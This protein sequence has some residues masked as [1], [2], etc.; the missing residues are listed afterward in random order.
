[1]QL[2]IKVGEVEQSVSP[3]QARDNFAA[4]I[5][6]YKVENPAKYEIKKDKLE[7]ELAKLEAACPK[8]KKADVKKEEAEEEA[9]EN[10]AEVAEV[11]VGAKAKKVVKESKT[12]K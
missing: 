1:M 7:A 6:T 10:I 11:K 12:K 9:E 3:E 2:N 4:I 5:E 8:K